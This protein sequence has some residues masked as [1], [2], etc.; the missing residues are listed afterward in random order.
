MGKGTET[1]VRCAYKMV[2]L[3]HLLGTTHDKPDAFIGE[4][5]IRAGA[6]REARPRPVLP[7]GNSLEEHVVGLDTARRHV[8][9]P[10]L[11]V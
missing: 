2:Y 7:I 8:P 10:P 6:P 3:G 1:G 11:V 4:D 9:P 5:E